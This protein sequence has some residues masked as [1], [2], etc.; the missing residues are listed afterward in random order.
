MAEPTLFDEASLALIA[1]GGAGKDGKVYS[2][3]PVP[4]YGPEK[5]TNGDF[6]TD[7]N[8]TKGN[9]ATISGGKA[10]IIGDGSTYVSITQNSVFT[11]GRKYRVSA[12]VEINSGLGLKFQDGATNENIGF[13][14][15][16]GTYVFDFIAGSNTSLAV[17]R[18]TGNTAFNSSVDNI[19]VK[20]IS[21]DGDFTFSRGSNL[22]ATR[23]GPD[24]L[25]E[26]GRENLWLQSTD[27][28]TSPNAT[29]SAANITGGQ[30]GYDG[31]S[32]AWELESLSN[33]FYRRLYQ[34]TTQTGVII[35]S[36]YAKAANTSSLLIYNNQNGHRAW[37]DLSS[38]SL[39]ALNGAIDSSIEDI[40]S[41]WY[42]CSISLL[43]S[44]S[45]EFWISPTNGDNVASCDLGNSILLQDAQLEIGLAATEPI[46]S[47]A[48]TGKAGL[49]EDEPRFDYSGGVTCPSLLLE[50]SRANIIQSSEYFQDDYWAEL[51]IHEFDTN[52]TETTAPTGSYSAT[53]IVADTTSNSN[54]V[55][56]GD[57]ALSINTQYAVSIFAK[58]AEY[59]YL[60]I[61][62]LGLGANGGARFN[63]S[64]G[65]VVAVN[66][67]DSATIEDYG[68]GWYRCI[69]VGTS[70]TTGAPYYHM[71]PTS[72]FTPFA[73]NDSDGIYI[74][75]AQCEQGSYPTSYIPNHSG[76]TITR[77]ADVCGDAGDVNT[78]NSTEGVLYAEIS[79]VGDGGTRRYI[80]LSDG[81]NSNDVRLYLDTNGYISAL[82]KVGGSTQ[83]FLSTNAYA[84]NNFNK[85]AFKYKE[86]DFALWVNG[87]EVAT[88]NSGL[89]NAA[90]TF[91]E[92]AFFGNSL[93]FYGKTKQVLVFKEA[94]S[95]TELIKLTT[96]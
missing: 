21:N 74:F 41:G 50:P 37:F 61:R 32:D 91:N 73:G 52:T 22:A 12:D 72:S 33:G 57:V 83:A 20:E 87:I 19:S 78:F 3:K 14:T 82:T 8:W 65:E 17:G 24:G 39:G 48:S 47:G 35:F 34:S 79:G 23:V 68:N 40:G 54:H 56:Y 69:A 94:L 45:S 89:V 90:N 77:G 51:G 7:S 71:S 95:D 88:D 84:Q 27:L 55:V 6:A 11:T 92:L 76:G 15:S 31:S 5:V 85:I 10:N 60:F 86:N 2:I 67:Y 18:R 43:T 38:G 16:S 63:I 42:R 75:G 26:K 93:P 59:D 25:I 53:K 9:G 36:I 81:G 1:S 13:A 66:G 29:T 49:L 30:S 80:S 46:E 64:A 70:T 58:A 44:A 28:G 96:I 62:G 4:E